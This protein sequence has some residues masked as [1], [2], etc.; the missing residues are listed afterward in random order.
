MRKTDKGLSLMKKLL[1]HAVREAGSLLMAKFESGIL[2][3][4]KGKYDLVTEADRQSEALIV[5]RIREQY[6][7]HDILA[8]EGNYDHL[9]SDYRWISR[10]RQRS[11]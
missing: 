11:G 6:P 9:G 5:K 3:E 10:T 8:E 7:D 4:F 2:V 1:L